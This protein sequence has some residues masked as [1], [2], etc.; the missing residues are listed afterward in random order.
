MLICEPNPA[1]SR[2][3]YSMGVSA[4]F[5]QVQGAQLRIHFLEIGNRRYDTSFEGL[6]CN[7]IFNAGGHRVT[8]LPFGVGDYDLISG[9]AENTAQRVDLGRGTA[10]A[11]G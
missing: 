7:H 10:S 2:T 1:P 3:A 8:G 9:G 5:G 6:Y 11:G 4:T